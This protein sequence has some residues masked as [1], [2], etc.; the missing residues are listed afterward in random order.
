MTTNESIQIVQTFSIEESIHAIELFIGGDVFCKWC[1]EYYH[2]LYE[3]VKKGN[4]KYSNLY[5]MVLQ[6]FYE[7]LE[8][9]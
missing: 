3:C 7:F 9:K 1:N 2:A 6:D 4:H 8:T 5:N